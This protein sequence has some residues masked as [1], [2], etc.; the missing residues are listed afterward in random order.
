MKRV[1]LVSLLI[2]ALLGGYGMGYAYH[3]SQQ[4]PIIEIESE[5]PEPIII[6]NEVPSKASVRETE[7]LLQAIEELDITVAELEEAQAQL[8]AQE[9]SV[10]RYNWLMD[11]M[12]DKGF[13]QLHMLSLSWNSFQPNKQLMEFFGW[14]EERLDTINEVAGKTDSALKAWETDQALY[15]E[16]EEDELIY[17]IPPVPEQLKQQYLADMSELIP[18]ED[19]AVL[20][21]QLEKKF[22]GIERRRQVKLTIGPAAFA[23]SG[24]PDEQYMIISTTYPDGHPSFHG[25][26]G[27]TSY[28]SYQEGRTIPRQWNHIFNLEADPEAGEPYFSSPGIQ[29]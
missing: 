22:E 23:H 12:E 1:T 5:I 8:K 24:E 16:S 25:S 21:S 13:S 11:L 28:M 14:D 6:T 19:F 20:K 3:M 4:P 29:P 27:P 7:L 2:I 10:R 18:E 15:V 17:E 9:E 26:K